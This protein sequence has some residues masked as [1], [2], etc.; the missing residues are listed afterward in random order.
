M[1]NTSSAYQFGQQVGQIVGAVIASLILIGGFAFF[2]F[3]LVKAIKTGRKGWIITASITGLPV[4]AFVGIFLY[5]VFLGVTKSSSRVREVQ[6]AKQ[7]GPSALLTAAMTSV[8]GK[9]AVPYTISLPWEGEWGKKSNPPYDYVFSYQDLYVGV[10]VEGF[11][12][13][14][15]Q[16]VCDFAQK[17]VQ[18]K[19]SQCSFTEPTEIKIGDL[20]WLSYDVTATLSNMDFKYRYF[21]YADKGRTAQIICWTGPVVFNHYAPVMNRI[22]ESFR[23]T[24][25]K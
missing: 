21:V 4:L 19:A 8:P 13:G 10:I 16:K 20:N 15:P 23:F 14:S 17:L 2:V 18:T 3:S 9:A 24:E 6:L 22:A 7:G 25:A 1:N 5:G 12:A 11:G